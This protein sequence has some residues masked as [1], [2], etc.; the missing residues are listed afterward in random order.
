MPVHQPFYILINIFEAGIPR[1]FRILMME[2]LMVQVFQT[3]IPQG[4]RFLRLEFL[5]GDNPQEHVSSTG[6]VP[7][8]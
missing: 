4:F 7:L 6:G 5:T 3:A 8:E 1:G 2:F